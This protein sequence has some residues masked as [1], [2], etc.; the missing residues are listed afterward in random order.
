MAWPT[1]VNFLSLGLR[2]SW[3]FLADEVT[4]KEVHEC[5]KCRHDFVKTCLVKRREW[6]K[7]SAIP[8]VYRP[9]WKMIFSLTAV[10]MRLLGHYLSVLFSVNVFKAGESIYRFLYTICGPEL[11]QRFPFVPGVSSLNLRVTYCLFHKKITRRCWCVQNFCINWGP[12]LYN[13][14]Y[15]KIDSTLDRANVTH[16]W[17]RHSKETLRQK[18]S[19]WQEFYHGLWGL[20]AELWINLD[21][22]HPFL[23]RANF[24]SILRYKFQRRFVQIFSVMQICKDKVMCHVF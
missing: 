13:G 6:N 24:F 16:S 17:L 10:R 4:H 9:V 7:R 8:P 2:V 15:R 3:Q 23:P 21:Y 19:R 1:I 5:S 20:K 14:N 18:D 12:T 11:V 22:L